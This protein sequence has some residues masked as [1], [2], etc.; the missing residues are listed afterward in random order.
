VGFIVGCCGTQPW[1]TGRGVLPLR[2]VRRDKSQT[3]GRIYKTVRQHR[4]YSRQKAQMELAHMSY[5]Y[6]TENSWRSSAAAVN[7]ESRCS[8][9][10]NSLPRATGLH[11]TL[12]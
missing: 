2:A 12:I 4:E 1:N 5:S 10:E 7:R 3:D 8:H 6:L 9:D 11:I